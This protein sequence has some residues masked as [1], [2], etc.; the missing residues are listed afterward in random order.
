M[1]F[2]NRVRLPFK[3]TRPQFLEERDVFRKANGVTKVLN[4]VIRKQYEGE[5]DLW[6]E[7]WHERFKIAIAHD[8]VT[9]EGE[10]Y[11]GGVVQDGDYTIN[12]VEFLDYPIAKATFKILVTPFDASNS[13]CGICSDDFIQAEA[14]DDNVG[15]VEENTAFD[16]D[17]L[18]ND[19][20]C[21]DPITL[22]IITYNSTYVQSVT[23]NGDNT[24]HF[25]L[26]DD[27]VTQNNIVLATY[28]VACDNGQ[29]DE[30]N[31]IANVTG[32]SEAEC[33]SPTNLAI[34]DITDTEAQADWDDMAGALAYDFALYLATDLVNPVS[35]GTVFLSSVPLSG[36]L[37]ETDYVLFV[38]TTCDDDLASNYAQIPFTTTEAECEETCGRYR[39]TMDDG[40][41][42]TSHTSTVWYTDCN[43]DL[44]S[45]IVPNQNSTFI[46]ALQNSPGDAVYIS[47]LPSITIEYMGLCC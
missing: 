21:C 45:Q 32:S 36:L 47:P 12:W 3:L 18:A 20:V 22:T 23:I 33:L 9:I 26:K 41:G 14:N 7:K 40:S 27:L 4:V 11:I 15:E 34:T 16:V 38:R 35:S 44:Q 13:N 37:P 2:V 17:V 8:N 10:K 5:T 46:C 43:G 42:D 28:R 25:I 24:L 19:A 29:F 31:V 39:L 30:A 1:A 6:P